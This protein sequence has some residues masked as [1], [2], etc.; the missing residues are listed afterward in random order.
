MP[1]D[2]PAPRPSQIAEAQGYRSAARAALDAASASLDA[3]ERVLQ[4]ALEDGIEGGIEA[5]PEPVAP[6]SEHLRH[7]RP[8]KPRK[9]D[10][11]AELRAFVRAR[12][13][14]MTFE[15]IAEAIA[16][17]FP[18][19][20]RVRRSAIHAWWKRSTEPRHR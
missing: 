2:D 8:G 16:A 4:S 7:H 9:L 3:L 5:L 10:T 14:R 15:E 18:P 20:R 13:D 17:H 12:L 19:E 6:P 1:A 11:D